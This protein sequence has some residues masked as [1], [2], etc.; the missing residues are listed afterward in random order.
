MMSSDFWMNTSNIDRFGAVAKA[1]KSV[2]SALSAVKE[3]K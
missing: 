1:K 3:K 2:S